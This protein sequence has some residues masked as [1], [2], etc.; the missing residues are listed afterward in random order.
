[1][2][3]THVPALGAAWPCAS[4]I[5]G[6]RGG[7]GDS[8]T[9]RSPFQ[10]SVVQ[11]I[12]LLDSDEMQRLVQ[13]DF[14]FAPVSEDALRGFTRR[15]HAALLSR[16][17]VL[18]EAMRAETGFVPGDC[19]EMAQ[20][21]LDFVG[22]F[23]N[24]VGERPA[25]PTMGGERPTTARTLRLASCA[26]G[27]VAIVLPQNA[28]LLVAVTALLHALRA[29][30]RIILRAPLQ[31]ARSAALLASVLQ[32]AAAPPDAVSV[33]LVRAKAFVDAVYR[34]PTPALVHYM[35]SA[36]HAPA[37]LAQTF[38]SGKSAL[39]DG[40][41]NAWV[42]VAEDA[43]VETAAAILT[44]GAVHYNGQ[45]CTSVNG[46]VI[47]PQIYEPV[48]EQLVARWQEMRFG[49]ALGD[50]VE[51]GPVFDEAQA[52]HGLDQIGRSGGR[53]LC[54]GRRTENLLHPTLI[55]SPLAE[56]AL[57]REGVFGPALWIQ[58]GTAENFVRL[59]PKNRY[60]LCAGV[61]SPSIDEIWWLGH[62]P[63]LA[64]FVVNGDPSVEDVFEPWGGYPGSGLNPVGAWDE[65]YRR[66]VQVDRLG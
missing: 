47:H 11:E 43:D 10:Q 27:T 16:S 63:N 57:V 1:M 9:A 53:I 49:S 39:I 52:A 35:G 42:Y 50:D 25:E 22:G 56:S 5:W 41:G 51:V 48:R 58:S 4:L 29:G 40:Q 61:L 18:V 66:L 34:A 37:L 23:W 44:A 15:L 28:F 60:P 36:H 62:L 26:W 33:V 64:R 7:G 19:R 65:K 54:G 13:P 46:A 17:E 3:S 38:E 6:K 55:E 24:A 20:G 14:S 30:N 32:E 31:S 21:T 59:W 12:T 8:L 45:T 2:N